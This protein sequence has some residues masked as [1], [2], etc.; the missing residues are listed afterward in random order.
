MVAAL[1]CRWQT[2]SSIH[3][4]VCSCGA[5]CKLGGASPALS[6]QRKKNRKEWERR[7]PGRKLCWEGAGGLQLKRLENEAEAPKA[8]LVGGGQE[9]ACEK[10]DTS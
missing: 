5:A 9:E 8:A 2:Y 3:A 10:S 4:K 6:R 7:G 1:L